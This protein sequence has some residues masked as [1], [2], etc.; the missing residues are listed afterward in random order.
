MKTKKIIH[1]KDKEEKKIKQKKQEKN[2]AKQF[3]L[4]LKRQKMERTKT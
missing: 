2:L 3:N 1:K 4:K